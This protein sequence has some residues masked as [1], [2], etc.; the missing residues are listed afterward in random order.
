MEMGTDNPRK[1]PLDH[2]MYVG[3]CMWDEGLLGMGWVN[4]SLS[5][6]RGHRSGDS[7]SRQGKSKE[8]CPYLRTLGWGWGSKN[9]RETW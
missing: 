8:Q 3:P 4:S 1:Q 2:G 9:Y 6:L 5:S 7:K